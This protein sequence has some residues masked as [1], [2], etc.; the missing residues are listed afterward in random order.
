MLARLGGNLVG[1]IHGNPDDRADLVTA[2]QVVA[3]FERTVG[4]IVWN[5]WPPGWRS[6]RP[7]TT[8]APTRPPPRPPTTS[9]GSTAIRRWLVPVAYQ[10]LP[11]EL[12]PAACPLRPRP[13]AS[14]C[15][16]PLTCTRGM[17]TATWRARTGSPAPGVTEVSL[18]AAYHAVRRGHPVPSRCTGS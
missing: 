7:S 4:R 11:E 10:G 12:R 18:A 8:A 1:S 15:R 13:R 17:W 6:T 5:G 16:S 2:R 3:V 9:V 14:R